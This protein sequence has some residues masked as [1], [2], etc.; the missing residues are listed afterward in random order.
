[1]KKRIIS[2]ALA[3][4]MCFSLSVTAF[5]AENQQEILLTNEI[6]KTMTGFLIDSDGKAV[7]VVGTLVDIK[8]VSKTRSLCDESLY[9]ATYAYD[10]DLIKPNASSTVEDVDGS[11]AVRAYLTVTYSTKTVSS[12]QKY[13][14]TSVSGRWTI[15]DSSVRVSSAKINYGCSDGNVIQTN[16]AAVNNNFSKSTGF[17]TYV[18]SFSGIMGAYLTL[19]LQMGETRTWRFV[20]PNYILGEYVES[21]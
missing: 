10:I 7:E 3:L 2:L 20:L 14:L 1:M 13:L 21:I 12:I 18:E 17:S 8:D 5:A 6:P 4:M 15:L 19:N 9:Q 16:Q 11:A